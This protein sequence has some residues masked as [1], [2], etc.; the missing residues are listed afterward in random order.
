[1]NYKWFI[2]IDISKKTL[3]VVH[4][5]KSLLKKSP[6]IQITNNVNGFKRL[7]K[8]LKEYNVDLEHALFCMEH[9]GVYGFEL[10]KFLSEKANYCIES[11]LH[12]K[13]SLGLTR[14]KN[15][16][17]DA[18]Q[19]ARFCYLHREEL[20][21]TETPSTTMLTLRALIN[22][23]DRLVKIRAVDK[24]I[25]KE[26]NIVENKECIRRAK[27]RVIFLTK[28]I[29][30]IEKQIE[31][32]IE[33]DAEIEKN[34]TLAKSITGIGLV[35]AV[36]FI[37]YTNNFCSISDPR[38]YACYSGIA[39]FEHSSGTSIKGKTRV[40]KLANKK[41]KVYLTNG[42]SSAIINDPELKIYYKRKRD[43]GKEHGT[44]LNAV[45]FKLITRVFATVKRGTPY[46]KLRQAG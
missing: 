46:V 27:K 33:N 34:Y 12:I 4:Y 10:A 25:I 38:K 17:I 21:P 41:I 31:K 30:Q 42:A 1:M 39:P 37:L 16:K 44:V 43:E 7:I 24:M 15:D 14:G 26:L 32:T 40:S 35:N 6:Y 3:D 36:M 5:D 23:R 45:K 19:I 18:Y 2:G 28:D 22:E 20:I 8:W 13:R 29:D 9:T 11:P